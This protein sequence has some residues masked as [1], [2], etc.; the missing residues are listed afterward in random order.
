MNLRA[1]LLSSAKSSKSSELI[2]RLALDLAAMEANSEPRAKT[3]ILVSFPRPFGRA[4]SSFILLFGSFKS[5]PL[6]LTATSTDSTK[7][8]FFSPSRASEIACVNFLLGHCYIR[9]K[10]SCAPPTV[11]HPYLDVFKDF[12]EE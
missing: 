1:F 9:S 4:I 7:L 8:R 12:V 6:R 11:L 5:T 10:R 3:P 2:T